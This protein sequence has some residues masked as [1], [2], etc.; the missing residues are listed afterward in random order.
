MGLRSVLGATAAVLAAAAVGVGGGYAAGRMDRPAPP[1]PPHPAA[2]ESVAPLPA[3]DQLEV[4]KSIPYAPDI[5][6]PVL[7]TG[8]PMVKKTAHGAGHTWSYLAP[9]HWKAY[10]GH[11]PDPAGTMRWRPGDEPTIGGYLLRVLPI[12]PTDTP[13]E[14]VESRKQ[15][16]EGAYRDVQVLHVGDDSIWFAYRTAG[17]LRRFDY[18]AWVRVPGQ[19]Y[20]GFELSVAGRTT[21]QTGL[22]DLLD[23]VQA[24]VRMVR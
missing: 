24:S 16:M 6:Y 8:L 13:A 15:K 2:L 11:D 1:P 20:A 3:M 4:A 21:D 12:L 19:P 14:Q 7:A 9:A 23:R 22:A 5:S 18:F 10:P 17:N